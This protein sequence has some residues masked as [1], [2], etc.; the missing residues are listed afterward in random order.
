MWYDLHTV[1]LDNSKVYIHFMSARTHWLVVSKYRRH[2]EHTIFNLLRQ[3]SAKVEQNYLNKCLVL[4][5]KSSS[6]N[7]VLFL[8]IL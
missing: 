7:K 4:V 1:F 2:Q 8:N 5:I 3:R 6:I